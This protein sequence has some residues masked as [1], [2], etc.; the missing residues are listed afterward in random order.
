LALFPALLSLLL[1]LLS[2]LLPALLPFL[3]AFLPALLPVLLTAVPVPGT[4]ALAM[5]V[6]LVPAAPARLVGVASV[7]SAHNLSFSSCSFY[8]TA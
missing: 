3:L 2:T 5:T 6:T 7:T 1:T 8:T 4:A